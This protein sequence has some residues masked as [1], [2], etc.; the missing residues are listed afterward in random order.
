[1]PLTSAQEQGIAAGLTQEQV[2]HQ[3]F[4]SP[5]ARAAR[6]N[7]PY[8]CY[9]G[10]SFEQVEYGI[11]QGLSRDQVEDL[12]YD[13]IEGLRA[14]LDKTQVN[15]T[16]FKSPHAQAARQNIP[17]ACFQGLSFEQVEYGICQG[18]SRD[19]VENL[20]YMQIRFV[21]K[22]RLSAGIITP[23][24][25]TADKLEQALKSFN[26]E[27]RL[28][29]LSL[30]YGRHDT[31]MGP[32]MFH[33]K[34]SKGEFF[35]KRGAQD[36]LT[37]IADFIIPHIPAPVN[38]KLWRE[39]IANILSGSDTKAKE[40]SSTTQRQAPPTRGSSSSIFPAASSAKNAT[41]KQAPP[42]I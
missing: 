34:N 24:M 3:W 6:K 33:E 27:Q 10:L 38:E 36:I 30:T 17:Y 9:Q 1:M 14:G 39:R 22:H 29:L 11:L 8:A 16:W 7:I 23:E 41:I 18:L 32:G 40:P 15:H 25:N 42:G 21:I 2:N 28:A 20:D 26:K 12:N 4:T 37:M 19:Q 31:N 5:H 13:Q 35:A